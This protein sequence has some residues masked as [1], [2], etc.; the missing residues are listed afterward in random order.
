MAAQGFKLF[1]AGL[2]T[3]FSALRP[4]AA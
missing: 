3:I 1:A 2:P 4:N